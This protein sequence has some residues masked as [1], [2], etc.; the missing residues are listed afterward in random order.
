MEK[1]K[2]QPQ[3]LQSLDALRGF[4]MLFIMGGASLFVALATLFPNPFFQAIAGQMEHVERIGASRH[5]L[6]IVPLYCGYLVSVLTREAT[7]KR[8]DGRGDL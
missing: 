3:R 7:R 4:D 2:Q 1:Q 5:D 6:P 8:Y